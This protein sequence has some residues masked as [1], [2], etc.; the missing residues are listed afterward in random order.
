MLYSLYE[1]DRRRRQRKK[2]GV[3]TAWFVGSMLISW[4]VFS[5]F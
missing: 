5:N 2:I 3:L 4:L 1:A